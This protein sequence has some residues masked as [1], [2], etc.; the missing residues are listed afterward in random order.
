MICCVCVSMYVWE[1][2]RLALNRE[3]RGDCA[4]LDVMLCVRLSGALSSV[5]GH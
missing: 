5:G 3:E 2:E 4:W 1:I